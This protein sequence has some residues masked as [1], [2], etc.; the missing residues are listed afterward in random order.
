MSKRTYSQHHTASRIFSD[1][2]NHVAR[3]GWF[4][5]YPGSEDGRSLL[6][7]SF[8]VHPDDADRIFALLQKSIAAYGGATDWVLDRRE[9]NRFFLRP[10]QLAVRARL[11]SNIG[12][13]ASEVL[14]LYPDLALEA[15]RDLITLS[16]FVYRDYLLDRGYSWASKI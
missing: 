7:T 14:E 9:H 15:A 11:S 12:V 6:Y 16:D 10:M 8:H 5:A 4:G 1:L 2:L 3:R 13:A